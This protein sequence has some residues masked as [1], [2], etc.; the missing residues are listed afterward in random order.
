MLTTFNLEL[1]LQAVSEA[2]CDFC[3]AQQESVLP[4]PVGG[5]TCARCAPAL[6]RMHLMVQGRLSRLG[7]VPLSDYLVWQQTQP[8]FWQLS[9]QGLEV[10]YLY[11]NV[12]YGYR[13][14]N[15]LNAENGEAPG[16]EAAQR[17]A[18]ESVQRAAS[19]L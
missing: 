5:N 7:G 13:W 6:Y 3:G 14:R 2:T 9:F 12:P 4:L 17:A 15:T 11:R 18:V 19:K 1:A 8:G 10:A 16:Q